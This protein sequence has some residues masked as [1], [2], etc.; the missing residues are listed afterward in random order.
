MSRELLLQAKE[1]AEEM[2]FLVLHMY[3]DSLFVQKEGAQQVSDFTPL[4]EKIVEKTGLAI[5]LDGVY[6][7][8][9]F[10]S[11]KRDARVPVPNRYY[12]AFQ[13]GEIKARGISLRRH[14]TPKF[15]ADTQMGILKIL[16][17]SNDPRKEQS[18]VQEYV[19][20]R[21]YLLKQGK[22]S[23]EDLVI[24]QTLSRPVDAY[25]VPSPTA[26][27]ARQLETCGKNVQPG[28]RIRY[29]YVYG[30]D[31]VHAWGS[32]NVQRK[33]VNVKQY[34]HLLKRAE[35]EVLDGFIKPVTRNAS[36]AFGQVPA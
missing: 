13:G 7:W 34:I 28:M 14:D 35:E 24:S 23:I 11:S 4:L 33:M 1:M 27:A 29:L 2:N 17:K 26:R 9:V 15:V 5:T 30:G 32:G 36:F 25:R 3:V 12:G 22:I 10:P 19:S 20:K 21:I 31:G 8:L 18:E 6:R 16:G